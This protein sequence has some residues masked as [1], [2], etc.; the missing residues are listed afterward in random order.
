MVVFTF[1]RVYLFDCL[2][3]DAGSVGHYGQSFKIK[4]NNIL[5][6]KKMYF[7]SEKSIGEQSVSDVHNLA[8]TLLASR[9]V[10]FFFLFPN[11]SDTIEYFFARSFDP[12]HHLYHPYTIKN[13]PHLLHLLESGLVFHPFLWWLRFPILQGIAKNRV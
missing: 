11:S 1:F 5:I 12:H 9:P 8:M 7:C 13:T 10:D 6:S 2:M 3:G 4:S